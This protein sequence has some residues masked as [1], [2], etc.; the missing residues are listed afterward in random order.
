MQ[1][2]RGVHVC[3]VAEECM[4]VECMYVECMYVECMYVA[5]NNYFE[6]DHTPKQHFGNI[7]KVDCKEQKQLLQ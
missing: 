2:H 6:P 4:Y 3:R 7:V 5:G 1:S